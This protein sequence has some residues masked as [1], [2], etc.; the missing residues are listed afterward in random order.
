METSTQEWS[1]RHAHAGG[2]F[3]E[4]LGLHG[5]DL[6]GLEPKRRR[7]GLLFPN[8]RR[9]GLIKME[10]RRFYTQ[11]FCCP[12]RSCARADVSSS[13]MSYNRWLKDLFA[14]SESPSAP[15]HL[16]KQT[17]QIPLQLVSTRG[18]LCPH[19]ATIRPSARCRTPEFAFQPLM[20]QQRSTPRDAAN[21]LQNVNPTVAGATSARFF[22]YFRTRAVSALASWLRCVRCDDEA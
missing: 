9:G 6:L 1:Q 20:L 18:E 10:F 21:R 15:F 22:A 12:L 16:A 13:I 8:S 3:A 2:R 5:D 19:T 14:A 11:S 7:F 4:Q 17:I